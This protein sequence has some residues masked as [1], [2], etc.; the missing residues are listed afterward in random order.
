MPLR[1]RSL[2][3]VCVGTFLWNKCESVEFFLTL[4]FQERPS[5]AVKSGILCGFSKF[6]YLMQ[7]QRHKISS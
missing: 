7:C 2:C 1:D 3:R 4:R 5:G 6:T